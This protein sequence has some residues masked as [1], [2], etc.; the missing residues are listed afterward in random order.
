V[1]RGSNLYV[2]GGQ[3]VDINQETHEARYKFFDDLWVLSL[4]DQTWRAPSRKS[5]A[6]LRLRGEK[7]PPRNAHTAALVGDDMFVFGGSGEDGPTS[8]VTACS[9]IAVL[10]ACRCGV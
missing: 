9:L 1:A 5:K 3:Q 6:K 2:F 8:D 7:I 4:L 10:S